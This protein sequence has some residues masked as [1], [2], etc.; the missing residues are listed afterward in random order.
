M[1]LMDR[2][3]VIGR[4]TDCHVFEGDGTSPI[5]E[6]NMRV[7]YVPERVE[8]PDEVAEWR[9]EIEAEEARKE[10]AGEP[11]RWNNPRFAVRRLVVSR[12]HTAEVPV[13]TL[14]LC[15]ADYYDFLATSIYLDRG[16]KNGLT[17]RQQY[18]EGKDLLEV[19]SFMFCSFGVNVAVE[20]GKD[21][22]MLFSRRSSRV[23]GPNTSKWNS[24]ANEGLASNHDLSPDGR[25]S[26]HAAARRALR[27]ELA[28]L[29]S[30]EVDLELLGFGFDV[31]NNQWA[32][33]FRAVLT[34]LSEEDLRVRWSRG[35]ADKWEH[36]GH[37][38]VDAGPESVLRFIRDEPEESWTP[39]A[40]ALF[41]LALVRGAV[42]ARG[43]DPD[44][45]Y[46][47]EAVERRVLAEL[48]GEED[49]F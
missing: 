49:T 40:P 18:L 28:V 30:D 4:Q 38:F 27:E 25:V 10:A 2:F 11:Y 43:G 31:R 35:V 46:E 3:T 1:T 41:Y 34:D 9:R 15:D 12:T 45:R 19:P 21:G 6:E 44:A 13:A 37:A 39:C 22:K 16:Q 48:D 5:A 7:R 23:A 33:F 29:D 17:L 8:L 47:V 24:S 20:T 26:L 14:T 36:E 32:G 42:R